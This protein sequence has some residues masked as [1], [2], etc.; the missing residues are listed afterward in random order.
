ME[1]N[2]HHFSV[3]SLKLMTTSKRHAEHPHC[4]IFI[5]FGQVWVDTIILHRME[6][7]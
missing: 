3:V 1:R 2:D 6:Y 7:D 5:I 4:L